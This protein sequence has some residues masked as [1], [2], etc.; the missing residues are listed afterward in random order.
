MHA[1]DAGLVKGYEMLPADHIA[2]YGENYCFSGA[3]VLSTNQAV[4][5]FSS[6][7]LEAAL[8]MNT[9]TSGFVVVVEKCEVCREQPSA[10][11]FPA[12]TASSF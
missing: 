10:T 4:R 7:D 11:V 2:T 9:N 1:C 8:G 6:G 3:S 5:I 12:C